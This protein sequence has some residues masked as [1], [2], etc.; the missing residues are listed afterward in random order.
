M[1]SLML[2]SGR[3][4]QIRVHLSAIGHP[5]VGDLA[6]SGKQSDLGL[7]RPFLHATRLGFEHPENG[8]RMSFESSLPPELQTVLSELDESDV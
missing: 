4:H 3:T 1:V 5:V 7:D 2:D 6:Y 8:E